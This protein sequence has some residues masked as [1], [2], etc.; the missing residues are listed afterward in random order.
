MVN[1]AAAI[2]N[3]SFYQEDG[4]PIRRHQLAI[5]KLMLKLVFSSSMDAMLEATRVYGNLSQS[6]EV[7][8]FIV[9]HKVHRFTVTLLDSKSAEM[10]FSACGVLINLTLDPPNRACLSLEGASAKLLDCLTDLGPG[11]WQLAG[12]VCQAMW[13]L[14]GGCSESLLEAQESEWLLEILTT[15]SDEEEALKWIEDEDERDFHR[16]CWELQFLPVAQKLMKALQR[17]D[18]TA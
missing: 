1:V 14:T 6:K 13:N 18:P 8:E 3:L 5:A 11:D 15:Y 10:C 4:S 12:H 9:Q 2:N 16:A 17:P 7:R